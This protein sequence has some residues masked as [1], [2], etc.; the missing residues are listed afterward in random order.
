[1]N[2]HMNILRA[3]PVAVAIGLATAAF[4]GAPALAQ[5]P[6]ATPPAAAPTP[7]P[8]TN[9]K[10]LDA[11]QA[12]Y[13]NAIKAAEFY[14]KAGKKA[15]DEGFAGA[16]SLLRAAERS[17]TVHASM[18]AAH[19]TTLK[20]TPTVRKDAGTPEVK[21]TKENL[22][23]ALKLANAARE[24]DL[25]AGRRAAE[26]EGNRN[27]GH[28]FKDAREGVIEL[29]RGF[30][31]AGETLDQWKKKRDFFVGRTCGYMVEKLDL[32]KCPVCGKGRDDFEKVN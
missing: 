30:K 28:A 19:I 22:A 21:T 29:A 2:T 17:E 4:W 12:A 25:P 24:T 23:A 7:P 3:A 20:A 32:Q 18:F 31:D 15:D 5:G 27:A 1:M 9:D 16:A 26:S 10:T 14:G 6:N 11:L 13:T 8:P